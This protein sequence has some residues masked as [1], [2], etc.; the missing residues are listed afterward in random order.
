MDFLSRKRQLKPSFFVIGAQKSGTTALFSMLAEHPR[1]AAPEIKE[2]HFFD[3]FDEYVGGIE[4]YWTKFPKGRKSDFTFEA[5]PEY[6]WKPEVAA[7]IAKDLPNSKLILVLREPISRAHSAWNMFRDFKNSPKSQHLYDPRSF[8]QAVED[9]LA[10]R[11]EKAAHRYLERGY[12]A[13]QIEE[14]LKYFDKNKMMIVGYSAFLKQPAQVVNGVLRFLNL[15]AMD[16]DHKVF[17]VK[18]NKRSYDSTLDPKLQIELAEHY[19]SHN[20][21]LKELLGE[22]FEF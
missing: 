12:Y 20:K 2:L 14:Y 15:K 9:E 21:R 17:R 11:T 4:S 10:G 5:T 22:H 13:D 6:I 3:K 1:I 8:E 7:L 16:P 19:K 18:K